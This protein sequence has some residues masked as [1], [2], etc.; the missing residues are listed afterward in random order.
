MLTNKEIR[1]KWR[2]ICTRDRRKGDALDSGA[3]AIEL[4][5]W[6]ES[7][8]TPDAPE[9]CHVCHGEGVITENGRLRT[10]VFC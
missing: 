1:E 4:A 8:P 9:V 10:C 5:R 2:Q 3:F 6:V 7:R